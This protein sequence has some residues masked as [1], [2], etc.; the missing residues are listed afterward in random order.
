MAQHCCR[1]LLISVDCSHFFFFSSSSFGR[2]GWLLF[3]SP[4][5]FG[6]LSFYHGGSK[7]G[8]AL[9]RNI[10][11]SPSLKFKFNF[12]P[13]MRNPAN[14]CLNIVKL[15]RCTL[16]CQTV[17][18][19]RA[20]GKLIANLWLSHGHP[21]PRAAISI[22]TNHYPAPQCFISSFFLPRWIWRE[23]NAFS[24]VQRTNGFPSIFGG[25]KKV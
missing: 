11:S 14:Y 25:R 20:P 3:V 24:R 13:P 10:H 6:I 8:Q 12:S 2:R 17:C 23:R 21:P 19:H 7:F 16:I 5:D 4:H 18:K 9:N 15:V 1:K 22:L